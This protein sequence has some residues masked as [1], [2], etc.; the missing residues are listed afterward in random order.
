[1]ATT[2]AQISLAHDERWMRLALAQAE[3]AQAADE[4]PVG[5][6]LVLEDELI[7][8]GHNQT[9]SL[10]DPSA[11]A[12][13]QTLRAAGSRLG[14]Y[15]LPGSTMYVT[16]EPCLMCAGAIVHAR[17][18]RVV[19]AADDPKTGACGGCF[20]LLQDARHNHCVEVT[21]GVLAE[22]SAAILRAFFRARR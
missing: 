17:V 4:V 6:V 15:R 9:I 21:A 3:L 7:A 2:Q 18:A 12:E 19:Y 14:N 11:H 10:A 20:D 5:A 16:L 8:A 13:M 1:M 22:H